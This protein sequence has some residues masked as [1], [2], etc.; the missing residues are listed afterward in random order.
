MQAETTHPSP[1]PITGHASQ[2]SAAPPQLWP[3]VVLVG[4]FWALHFIVGGV[5]KPY[6]YGFLFSM[7]AAALLVLGYFGWWWTRRVPFRE[8][9]FAFVVVVG[10]GAVVAPFCDETVWFGLLTF[11]LPVVLTVWTLWMLLVRMTGLPWAR[12]G[13]LVVVALTW[14]YFTLIRMDGADGDLHVDMNWR[15]VLTKEDL[16]MAS[17]AA[18]TA[19]DTLAPPQVAASE[20]VLP[21]KPGDWPG[22]RGP[23]RDG[24]IRGVTITTDWTSAPPR[25]VWRQPVGPAWSSVI[26]VGDR[27]FTQE[28]RGKQEAVVCYDAATG[29]E[30]WSHEDPARFKEAVSRAGPRATPT[31]ADGRL[32]TLG[33]TGILN[34]FNAVTGKRSWRRDITADSGAKVPMWGFTGS[35]LVTHGKVIVFAGGSGSDNL[36]AYHAESGEPAW[37]APAGQESY[38]SPQPATLGGKAQCLLLSDHGLTAVD[39]ATGAVLWEHGLNMPGAP[40]A[41]QP[42]VIDQAQLVVGTLA[43]P[44]VARIEVTP[45][46]KSWKVTELWATSQMKTEFPNFVVH[47]GYIYGFD[48]ATFC[49]VDAATGARRWRAGRYGRGQVM[50]LP[51]QSLLLVVSEYGE[52]ILLAAN[53]ERSEELGRFQALDGKTWNHPVIAHGRLYVR[54]YEEM[55]CYELGAR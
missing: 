23:D 18:H 2:A 43:G 35:P 22:F 11:A 31:F 48:A 7:A 25:L 40:R 28:Q 44:G 32:Y 13:L 49:C 20:P 24:V 19:A 39:P 6:F 38:S 15:W 41:V 5:E 36:L 12:P 33:A 45:E 34:C 52:A 53:P 17:R 30:L 9:L 8:R 55:A 47:Q 21:Q 1:A 54:N 3:A 37:T 14:G 46:G 26:V 29:Q 50:L 16:F 27:L 10:T 4:L 42:Q 51:D